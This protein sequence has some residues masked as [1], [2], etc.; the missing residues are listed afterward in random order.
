MHNHEHIDDQAAG[1][2]TMKKNMVKVIAV[3]GGK[4]GVG[5]T[6][7]SINLAI[8]MAQLGKRVMVLDA[9]LG[10]ANCDVMLGLRVQRNLSHVLNGEAELDDILIEG[11]AG[12]KIIPATSGSQNMT[13][14][15]PAE[16]AGLIRAFSEMKTQVDILLIDTAAGISDMVMS[17]SRASQDVLVVVCDEPSSITD[18]YA[19]MKILSRDHDVQRFKIIANMVRSLREGQELF[20][21]LTRVTDRFLDVNL[22][23]VSTVPYDENVRKAARKQKAFVEAFPKSGASMAVKNLAM[24]VI[25]WPTPP[26]ASGHLEFFLEQLVQ[27]VDKEQRGLA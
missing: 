18:A 11:P 9:D 15:S 1:L 12:I 16:H 17:F 27:T 26:G 10:L 14:L 6:N 8:A 5:K 21:K 7:V 25:K 24:R 23:L 19:L 4:G 2:R 3:T 13:E 20:A 22:E